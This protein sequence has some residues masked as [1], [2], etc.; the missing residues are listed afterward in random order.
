M[1]T[2]AIIKREKKKLDEVNAHN[3]D[4]KKSKRSFFGGNKCALGYIISQKKFNL[5]VFSLKKN[6]LSLSID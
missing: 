3:T 6:S 2:R 1:L 5:V 4:T